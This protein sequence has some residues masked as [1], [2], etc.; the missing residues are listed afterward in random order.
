VVSVPKQDEQSDIYCIEIS[1]GYWVS[2]SNETEA[3]EYLAQQ[4]SIE[5]FYAN[6]TDERRMTLENSIAK[7]SIRLP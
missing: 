1:P 5:T 4:Q 6:L 2:T 7:D 3:R